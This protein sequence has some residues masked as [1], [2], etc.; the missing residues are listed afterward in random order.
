MEPNTTKIIEELN[1]LVEINNDRIK[2]YETALKET[3][4]SDL[5]SLFREMV[6]HSCNYNTVLTNEILRLGG[7]ATESTKNTGKL[8]RRW[9]GM[10]AM[11]TNYDRAALL[12]S[13]EF[14]ED[15]AL[16]VYEDVLGSDLAMPS[17]T[18]LLII[19]QK[20]KLQQDHDRIKQYRNLAKRAVVKEEYVF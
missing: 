9:M 17:E 2:G 11:V 4:E 14:G 10:R 8:Y 20:Q 16:E 12:S 18:R 15:A 3:G 6:N 1:K 13:C 19:K 5:K 7:E